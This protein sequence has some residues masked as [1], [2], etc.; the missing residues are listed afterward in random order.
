MPVR[1]SCGVGNK[2]D[3]QSLIQASRLVATLRL[4]AASA[5]TLHAPLS[6]SERS[7]QEAAT[8]PLQPAPGGTMVAFRQ[9]ETADLHIS[10]TSCA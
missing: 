3:V 6:N 7:I 10:E 4:V 9:P 5:S 2:T 8:D 1:I